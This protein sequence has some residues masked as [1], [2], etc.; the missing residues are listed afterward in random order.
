MKYEKIKAY[1]YCKEKLEITIS[2][3]QRYKVID[4]FVAILLNL[5]IHLMF[6]V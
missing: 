1:F 6:R 3:G 2:Q 4:G 5:K